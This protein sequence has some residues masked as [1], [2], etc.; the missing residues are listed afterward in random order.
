[1]LLVLQTGANSDRLEIKR[2]CSVSE[3]YGSLLRCL[4][5]HCHWCLAFVANEYYYRPILYSRCSNGVVR[6]DVGQETGHLGAASD[7]LL[8]W[9]WLLGRLARNCI[10]LRC[11]QRQLYDQRL[12]PVLPATRHV[13]NWVPSQLPDQRLHGT[14]LV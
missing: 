14:P 10:H 1:M 3:G 4:G 2:S 11:C 7:R 13:Q 12:W 6:G 5:V 9:L 8:D